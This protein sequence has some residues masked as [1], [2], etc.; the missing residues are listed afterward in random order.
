M[1]FSLSSSRVRCSPPASPRG[2]PPWPLPIAHTPLIWTAVTA[3]AK[4][5]LV[6]RWVVDSDVPVGWVKVV[7]CGIINQMASVPDGVP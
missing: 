1:A 7:W 6:R 3:S 4:T 5:M 2:E